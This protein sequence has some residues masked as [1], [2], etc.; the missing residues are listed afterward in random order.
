MTWDEAC[1]ATVFP[2]YDAATLRG[3]RLAGGDHA[4]HLASF[5]DDDLGALNIT[6]DLAVDLQD[7]LAD[8]LQALADDLE[9]VADY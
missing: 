9:I 3:R 7:T 5:A 2:A 1:R 4:G 8:D 6:L